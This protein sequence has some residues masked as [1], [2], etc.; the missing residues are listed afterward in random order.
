MKKGKF[1]VVV[2][3]VGPANDLW[4]NVSEVLMISFFMKF[5]TQ[6]ISLEEQFFK[7]VF[8]M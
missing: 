3:F 8:R 1:K 7:T 2:Y 6:N 4:L 5:L